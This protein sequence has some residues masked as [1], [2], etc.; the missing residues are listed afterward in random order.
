VAGTL[1]FGERIGTFAGMIKDRKFR[2]ILV[3]TGHGVGEAVSSDADAVVEYTGKSEEIAFPSK[4][5]KQL[6]PTLPQ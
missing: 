3:G 1:T 5:A 6:L 2:I 4:Q